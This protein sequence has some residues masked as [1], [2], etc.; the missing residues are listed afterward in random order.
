[1]KFLFHII[2]E[3][4]QKAMSPMFET[5]TIGPFLIRKLKWGGG[6]GGGHVS[7]SGYAPVSIFIT[8][9]YFEVE[10]YSELCQ[11]S[12]MEHFVKNSV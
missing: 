2:S 3:H 8:L 9:V 11:T 7:P 12:R 5:E 6:G 4:L 1:M 10:V